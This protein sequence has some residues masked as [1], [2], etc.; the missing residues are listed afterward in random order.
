MLILLAAFC[1]LL[2]AGSL[3]PWTL[4]PGPPLDQAIRHLLTGWDYSVENTGP[5]DIL[6]NLVIY[7]P[8]GFTGF[9]WSG[10][11]RNLT[12]LGV[13]LLLGT[14]L[15]FTV[16]TL[17]TYVQSRMPGLTDV[18]CNSV[19]T[20]LGLVLA[21]LFQRIIE[22]H[23][24]QRSHRHVFHFSSAILLLSLWLAGLGWPDRIFGLGVVPRVR[25]LL[26]PGAWSPPD[27]LNGAMPWMLAGCLLTVILDGSY[28]RWWLWALLPL[29][30][31]LM[32]AS[33]GHIF[34]WSY[35]GGA[36]AAVAL[37]SLLPQDWRGTSA[38]LAW[39]WLAWLVVEG[40][41]PFHV[42]SHP[43]P[44]G[45]V[46]FKE[47]LGIAWMPSIGVLLRKTWAYGAA[48]WLL[49]RTRLGRPAAFLL[50]AATVTFIEAAQCWLPRRT[51]GITDL[52]IAALAASL[53]WLVDRRFAP[54]TAPATL[55]QPG[56]LS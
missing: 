43:Q 21:A 50:T 32:L 52:V 3:F 35:L 22:A 39:L 51:P 29:V 55:D 13:P 4:R 49:S 8:I 1:F 47:M 11:R 10:W 31:G 37:H 42:S 53:F 20:A 5:R 48:F 41:R 30:F 19:S 26:H 46:P 40:L 38:A 7:I 24:G 6:V 12:R 15:S 17:Q 44:F 36:V 54:R 27:S 34:T 56:S 9:L 25:I 16:E 45:W 23:H 2:L 18:A 28:P 14:L 33:P